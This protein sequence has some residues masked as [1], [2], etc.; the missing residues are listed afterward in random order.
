[1]FLYRFFYHELAIT[2][3]VLTFFGFSTG[4]EILPH[5]SMDQ[6]PHRWRSDKSNPEDEED[7]VV[8]QEQNTSFTDSP[9]IIRHM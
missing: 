3:N 6:V 5:G 9:E 7:V 8:V 4:A 1:M 2:F